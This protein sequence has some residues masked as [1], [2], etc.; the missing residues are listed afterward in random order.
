MSPLAAPVD[1]LTGGNAAPPPAGV[2]VYGLF[3]EGCGWD[4]QVMEL[5]E[6]APKV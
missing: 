5:R 1:A 3:L 2:Y 6:S 4:E